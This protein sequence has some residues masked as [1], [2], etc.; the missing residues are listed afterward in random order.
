MLL[1]HYY[2]LYMSVEPAKIRVAIRVRPLLENEIKNGL[3]NTK[4]DCHED[5]AEVNLKPDER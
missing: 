3:Q 2:N 1:F 4:I 5:I